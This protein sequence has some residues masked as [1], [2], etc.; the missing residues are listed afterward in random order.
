MKIKVIRGPITSIL[1][2]R[3]DLITYSTPAL[4]DHV[5]RSFE[6]VRK[7]LRLKNYRVV[8][9]EQKPTLPSRRYRDGLMLLATLLPELPAR[10]TEK[11]E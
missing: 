5:G 7:E 8:E 3:G 11:T 4:W 1:W 6:E 10:R 9:D 2:V